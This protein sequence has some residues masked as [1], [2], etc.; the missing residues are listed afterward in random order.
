MR[1][2]RAS[3]QGLLVMRFLLVS[4]AIVLGIVAG[5][6][7]AFGA[8]PGGYVVGGVLGGIAVGLVA[9]VPF[10]DPYRSERAQ[11]PRSW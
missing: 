6:Y 7:V 4:N 1:S 10:T 11:H 5:L 2:P 9:A 8:R 3:V